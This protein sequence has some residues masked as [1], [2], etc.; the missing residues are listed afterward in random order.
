MR[1]LFFRDLKAKK[2]IAWSRQ[3]IMRLVKDGRFPQPAKLGDS[4]QAFNAWPETEIDDW[5]EARAKAR[6]QR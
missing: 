2:G 1:V 5:L 3:H 4:P 6:L